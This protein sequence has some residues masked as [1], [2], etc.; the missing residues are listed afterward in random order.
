MN[1]SKN[2][3]V[4]DIIKVDKKRLVTLLK[5]SK[6]VFIDPK[7]ENSIM[8][9]LEIEKYLKQLIDEVKTE[10]VERG[11]KIDGN[12]KG[13]KGEKLT[14]SLAPSGSKYKI[15]NGVREEDIKEFCKLSLDP[16][17]VE[18]YYK[19]NKKLPNGVEYNERKE[20]LRFYT[21]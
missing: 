18:S 2:R 11:K 12:F 1:E 6:G 14:I 8:K 9:L 5:D 17:K 4:G 21:K 10:I 7:S 13:V 3:E 19:L 16:S 15:L 20:S